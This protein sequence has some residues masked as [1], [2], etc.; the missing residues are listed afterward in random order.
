MSIAATGGLVVGSALRLTPEQY[1][2][3]QKRGRTG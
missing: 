3:H 1:E 2:A